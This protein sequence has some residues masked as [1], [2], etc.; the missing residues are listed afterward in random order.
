MKRYIFSILVSLT[1]SMAV[2]AQSSMTDTQVM[3]YVMKEQAAGTSQ[4][5]IVTKLMQKGV[6]IDQIRRIK[7]K[8]QRE[9]GSTALGAKND[10]GCQQRPAAQGQ[11]Q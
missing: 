8:Y 5:Q 3:E 10:Q 7:D 9:K 2:S 6:T 11:R 4:S 1:F